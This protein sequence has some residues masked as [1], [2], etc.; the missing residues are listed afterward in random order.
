METIIEQTTE[1]LNDLILINNDRYEGYQKAMKEIKDADLKNLFSKFSKQSQTNNESLRS[2]VPASEDT[3]DE[4]ETHLSGKIHR[5]WMDLKTALDSD[6]REK[7]LSSCEYGEDV[8]KKAYEDALA[9]RKQLSPDAVTMIQEQYDEIL[10]AHEEI[11]SLRDN[12]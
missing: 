2:L 7:I 10:K 11:R 9:D 5:M 8:A 4:D 3:P 12:E 6:D 1:T